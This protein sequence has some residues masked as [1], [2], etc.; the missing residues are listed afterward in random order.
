MKLP[1]HNHKD[2]R[3]IPAIRDRKTVVNGD[4]KTDQNC[5][6]TSDEKNLLI[7][8]IWRPVSRES[9]YI[10][11]NSFQC[12]VK[13]VGPISANC[14]AKHVIKPQ[15]SVLVFLYVTC[16]ITFQ[17]DQRNEAEC[18]LTAKDRKDIIAGTVDTV[19]KVS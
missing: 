2:T 18:A 11:G 17:A 19:F 9:L 8:D 1:L 3:K 7:L 13:H 4:R 10:M 16:L 12:P 5:R 15:V 14:G 6:H